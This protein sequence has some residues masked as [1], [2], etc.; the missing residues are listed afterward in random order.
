MFSKSVM[1]DTYLTSI[2]TIKSLKAKTE[3]IKERSTYR[4][5]WELYMMMTQELLWP[6]PTPKLSRSKTKDLIIF[7][8]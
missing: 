1:E 5:Y 6:G 2:S 7:Q 3:T 4:R 8:Y